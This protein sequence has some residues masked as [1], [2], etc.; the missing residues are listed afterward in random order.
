[1][2]AKLP[3]PPGLGSLWTAAA[4]V[5]DKDGQHGAAHA[6]LDTCLS[7]R[8]IRAEDFSY[9]DCGKP[10]LIGHPGVY[11]NLSH[12]DGMAVCLLSHR[13]CGVDAERIRTVR[14][15]VVRK[16]FSPAERA[17]LTAAQDP[18]RLFTRLWT[19]KEAYVKAVGRGL[20][21]PM[22]EVCFSLDGGQIRSNR[23]NAAF[24]QFLLP[25]H[26]VSVCVLEE[27]GDGPIISLL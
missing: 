6:L 13:E 23:E 15:A 25:D 17:A 12:C 11:F 3:L 10:S 4:P 20:S 19:L 24:A 2:A 1:M 14:D 22:R 18:D 5:R 16:V 8:G 9:G 21:Y 26:V 27:T 7:S